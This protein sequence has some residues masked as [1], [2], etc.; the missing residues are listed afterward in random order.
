MR[1]CQEL[2]VSFCRSLP[3]TK[4]EN[5]ATGVGQN[6]VY[7]TVAREILK[8]GA[9]RGAEN[10][11]ARFTRSGLCKDLDERIAVQDDRFDLLIAIGSCLGCQGL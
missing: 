3:F 7:S 1:S 5:G 11:E 8:S 2:C 4:R 9:M 6:A 10:D